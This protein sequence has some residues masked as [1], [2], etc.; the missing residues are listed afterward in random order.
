MVCSP[1]GSFVESQCSMWRSESWDLVGGC[2]LT[3]H[4]VLRV[5]IVFMGPISGPLSYY[6][7]SSSHMLPT[8]MSSTVL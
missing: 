3:E 8:M 1:K 4:F 6:M 7:I 5:I 2:W